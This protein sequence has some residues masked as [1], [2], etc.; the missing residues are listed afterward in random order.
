MPVSVRQ[1]KSMPIPKHSGSP[2]RRPGNGAETQLD[3][4]RIELNIEG[5]EPDEQ[6][7][8]PQGALP[9]AEASDRFDD[10]IVLTG[11]PEGA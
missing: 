2:L 11:W 1:Q 3:A 7:L 5:T 10:Y 9:V 6:S 8:P 4:G